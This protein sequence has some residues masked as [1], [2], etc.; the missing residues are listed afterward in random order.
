M[1]DFGS[2]LERAALAF[3]RT[4]KLRTMVNK[5]GFLLAL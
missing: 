4:G 2:A 1:G 3:S 5:M